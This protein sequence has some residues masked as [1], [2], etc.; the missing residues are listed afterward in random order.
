MSRP[1]LLFAGTPDFA[2]PALAALLAAEWPPVAVFTQPDRRAGRGRKLTPPPVKR[3]ADAHR[4]PVYQP[5]RLGEAEAVQLEELA[6]DLMVVVAYGQ[7]LPQRVL[8]IPR[9]GCINIHASLLPRWRGA[10]PIQRAL[11]AG[12]PES[13]VTLMRMDAGLDTGD[14]LAWART[15]IDPEETGGSLHDRLAEIGAQLL[16]EHLPAIVAGELTPVPQEEGEATYAAKLTAADSWLDWQRPAAE[17]ERQVR[18]LAPLPGAR[19]RIDDDT[20]VRVCAAQVGAGEAADEPGRIVALER[21][22]IAVSTA[23]DRLW[24]TRLQ[25][26]GGREQ[27]AA[28]YLNGQGRHLQVGAS[29]L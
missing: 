8:A 13:G 6:P 2:V 23:H 15:P 10:A 17:L 28:D 16:L 22:G 7:I 29:L 14:M 26:P 20:T 21:A 4:L 12:D 11:M 18:A 3:L 19:L 1:R 24:I 5:E 9:C 25:P 27:A